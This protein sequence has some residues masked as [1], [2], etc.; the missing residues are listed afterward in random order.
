MSPTTTSP[1]VLPLLPPGLGERS[2]GL[3]LAPHRGGAA[4]TE[5]HQVGNG[6]PT[7]TE[8]IQGNCQPMKVQLPAEPLCDEASPPPPPP[9]EGGAEAV[10]QPKKVLLLAEAPLIASPLSVQS[11]RAAVTTTL[12]APPPPPVLPAPDLL[13]PPSLPAP[14]LQPAAAPGLTALRPAAVLPPPLQE[15]PSLREPALPPPPASPPADA[16]GIANLPTSPPPAKPPS[17][18]VLLQSEPQTPQRPPALPPSLPEGVEDSP[19]LARA[20]SEA[21][22][23]PTPGSALHGTGQCRP[24]AWVWKSSGC[25][26]GQDCTHCH[27]CPEGETKARRKRKQAM[28]RLGLA[29][30]THEALCVG[31]AGLSL[32]L[33]DATAAMA[34]AGAPPPPLAQLLPPANLAPLLSTAAVPLVPALPPASNATPAS[35]VLPPAARAAR[36]SVALPGAVMARR[37]E[38]QITASPST[39]STNYCSVASDQGSDDHEEEASTASSERLGGVHADAV[40][41]HAAA[42]RRRQSRGLPA[43]IGPSPKSPPAPPPGLPS[44]AAL[45]RPSE[46]ALVPPPQEGSPA[47]GSQGA[48][49]WGSA[50]HVIGECRPCA[51]FWKTSGCENAE[52]CGFCHACLPGELKMRK[53]AKRQS[54]AMTRLGLVAPTS[55]ISMAGLGLVASTSE[56]SMAVHNIPRELL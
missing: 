26:N 19:E 14:E 10:R 3:P 11:L 24:C 37:P 13:P 36:G 40:H 6:S 22:G 44:P 35:F 50:L 43:P 7:A 42:G 45:G 33:A 16:D 41:D 49:S 12:T 56:I 29:T 1:A 48:L 2:E 34:A 38:A 52:E 55:D 30:P 54:R 18:A 31:M 20:N 4:A 15:A 17:L 53:K 25:R 9:P 28:A 47:T 23:T 21:I 46:E 39:T 51:W 27:L 5:G 8:E 32:S